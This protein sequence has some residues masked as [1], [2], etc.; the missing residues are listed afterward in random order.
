MTSNHRRQFLATTGALLALPARAQTAAYPNRPI[1]MVVVSAAG[2]ILDTIGRI[3]ATG[4]GPALGQNVVVENRAGAGGIPGTEFV[5]RS[6]PDGYTIGKVSTSHSIN[7]GLYPKMPYDTQKDLI[8]VSH[9]A[10]LSL[11]P[12]L[13]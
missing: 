10:L 6:A 2:G 1:K 5:A 13:Y 11:A 4:I 9:T 7:P 3:V 8:C 12:T